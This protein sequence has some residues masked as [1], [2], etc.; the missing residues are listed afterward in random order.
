MKAFI[1][2]VFS[3]CFIFLNQTIVAISA[4]NDVSIEY[5]A[6]AS[7]RI[8]SPDGTRI[9]IDPY[10]SNVWIGYAYPENLSADALVITH[11]HYDHD[12]GAYRNL[13]PSWDVVPKIFRRTGHYQVNDISLIGVAGR[14]ADPYGKEFGQ[15]NVVWV[16][17]V[18]GIR[19]AH[20]GDNGP[21]TPSM[22]KEIGKVDILMLPADKD[23]HILKNSE[24]LE[25]LTALEPKIQIP[26]HYCIPDLQPEGKCPGGLFPIAEPLMSGTR[27]NEIAG[28]KIT[29]HAKTLP[30]NAEY[31]I[32]EPSPLIVRAN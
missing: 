6:H 18:G 27:I 32:F 1:F 5:I 10:A 3:I 13:P 26:M 9:I 22:A 14:H 2:I 12:G 7:F 21:I 16:I 17:E 23:E 8:T 11:P 15:I 24:A 19:I 4:E 30:E 28:N 20:L 29:V 31:W 25:F